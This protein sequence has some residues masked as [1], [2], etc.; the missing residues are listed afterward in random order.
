M[1]EGWTLQR[2]RWSWVLYPTGS[3]Q[4]KKE[5]ALS[6]VLN[7]SNEFTSSRALKV[8]LVLVLVLVLLEE[9]FLVQMVQDDFRLLIPLCPSLLSAGIIGMLCHTGFQ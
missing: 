1:G 9:G 7:A 2:H 5:Q 4:C 3:R 6:S 8:F